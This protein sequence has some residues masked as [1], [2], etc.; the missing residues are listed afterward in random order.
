MAKVAIKVK[1]CLDEAWSEWFQG[2]A[3]THIN[4]NETVLEGEVE[5]QPALYGI[6]GRLRDLGLSLVAVNLIKEPDHT[7]R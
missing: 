6:I 1:G 5:D 7:H 3:I 2:F 4:G